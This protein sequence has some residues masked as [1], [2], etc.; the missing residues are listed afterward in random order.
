M[1][2]TIKDVYTIKFKSEIINLFSLLN[3]LLSL[4]LNFNSMSSMFAI[5]FEL[6]LE[7]IIKL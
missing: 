4:F 5:I 1:T 2:N 7:N 3:Y 6:N